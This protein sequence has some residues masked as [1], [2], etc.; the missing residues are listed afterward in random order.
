MPFNCCYQLIG[1]TNSPLDKLMYSLVTGYNN[2]QDREVYGTQ[3][4][5]TVPS[6][7]LHRLRWVAGLLLHPITPAATA[8]VM[9]CSEFRSKY[10]FLNFTNRLTT[11]QTGYQWSSIVSV[12]STS[13]HGITDSQP[14]TRGIQGVESLPAPATTGYVYSAPLIFYVPG[15]TKE[16]TSLSVKS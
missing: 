2:F 1:S 15:T 8:G 11:F 5:T 16:P 3:F 14:T 6:H 13:S 12:V 10:L 9:G 7:W 4:C